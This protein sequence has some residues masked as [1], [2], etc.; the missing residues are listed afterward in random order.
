MYSDSEGS[1]MGVPGMLSKYLEVMEIVLYLKNETS[2][3]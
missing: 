2:Y 3:T 1:L